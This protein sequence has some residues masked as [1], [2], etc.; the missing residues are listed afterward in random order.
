MSKFFAL[1]SNNYLG[2][3]EIFNKEI[4]EELD[5]TNKSYSNIQ[6]AIA[7]F[8]ESTLLLNKKEFYFKVKN[9]SIYIIPKK[10]NKDNQLL[11][12]IIYSF[13]SSKSK[14]IF[15]PSQFSFKNNIH[16]QI[17]ASYNF[18][19]SHTTID[20]K[21]TQL[22]GSYDAIFRNNFAGM[23]KEPLDKSNFFNRFKVD[24]K[25][26]LNIFVS[27]LSNITKFACQ[28]SERTQSSLFINHLFSYE[29]TELLLM[30]NDAVVP[31]EDLKYFSID[32]SQYL[33]KNTII[34]NLSILKKKNSFKNIL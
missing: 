27:K 12:M 15:K 3:T 6:K 20:L 13:E 10:E 18:F 2:L 31:T 34:N 28:Y 11:N 32:I 24:S 1:L 16:N 30:S 29:E 4:N 22:A 21:S 19:P 8:F 17:N 14:F 23:F 7:G 25:R 26:E 9:N 5:S 33:T